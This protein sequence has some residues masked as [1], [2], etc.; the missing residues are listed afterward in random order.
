MNTKLRKKAK[1]NFQR[2]FFKLM[3]SAHPHTGDIGGDI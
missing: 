1:N 3:N 2:D